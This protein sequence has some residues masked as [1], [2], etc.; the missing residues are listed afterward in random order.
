MPPTPP[1]TAQLDRPHRHVTG[2]IDRPWADDPSNHGKPC[3]FISEETS[4][5]V[6]TKMKEIAGAYHSYTCIQSHRVFGQTHHSSRLQ[7]RSTS[8][9]K[10]SGTI[11]GHQILHPSTRPPPQLLPMASMRREEQVLLSRLKRE[12]GKAKCILSSQQSTRFKIGSFE[13]GNM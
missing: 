3:R 13:G 4:A 11:A 8:G 7:Q 12:A 10:G 1:S 5:M 6:L 2:V 9:D